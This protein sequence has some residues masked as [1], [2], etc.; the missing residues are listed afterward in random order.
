MQLVAGFKEGGTVRCRLLMVLVWLSR[1]CFLSAYIDSGVDNAIEIK[2]VTSC[3]EYLTTNNYQ[4]SDLFWALRGGGGGTYGVVTS[5]TYRTYESLPVAYYSFLANATDA[6]A[7]KKLVTGLFQFQPNLTDAGWGGYGGMVESSLF[8]VAVAPQMSTEAANISTQPLTNY[9]SSLQS[10]GVS[11]VVQLTAVPSWYE[12]YKLLFD[13]PG[14]NGGNLMITSRL[15]SRDTL[16]YR[17]E[18]VAEIFVDCQGSFKWV[19]TYSP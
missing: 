10:Q 4:N 11:S 14:Q 5:V 16:A 7:M 18:D 6:T 8:F 1:L 13:A 19:H 2:V 3:G 17:S 15:F 12:W 9:A